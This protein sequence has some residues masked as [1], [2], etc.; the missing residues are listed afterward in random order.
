M[1][2]SLNVCERLLQP[3]RLFHPAEILNTPSAAPRASG[4]YGWWLKDPPSII[5]VDGTREQDGFHLLY[6]GIAPHGPK[7]ASTLFHRLKTHCRG[8]I[9][10][11]TFRRTLASLLH[12]PLRLDPMLTHSKKLGLPRAHEHALSQWMS[13]YART[14]WIE[15]AEPWNLE[16]LLLATNMF[17]LNI[18]GSKHAF[19][20]YLRVARASL[21]SAA[22]RQDP[23]TRFNS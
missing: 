18:G 3:R 6:I 10:Q 22:I 12:E 23:R 20:N 1:T 19:A 9:A 21:R 16:R 4:I 11:S 5:P 14:A 13:D 7:S 15:H 17:P 8:P 2:Y